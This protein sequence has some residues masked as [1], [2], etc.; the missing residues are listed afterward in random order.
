MAYSDCSNKKDGFPMVDQKQQKALNFKFPM[1]LLHVTSCCT[2]K[3]KIIEITM[4]ITCCGQMV[5]NKGPPI[6]T[7]PIDTLFKIVRGRGLVR[8]S[9]AND[10]FLQ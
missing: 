5:N 10:D 2:K 3:K 1:I 9:S 6:A 4:M 7:T 8:R